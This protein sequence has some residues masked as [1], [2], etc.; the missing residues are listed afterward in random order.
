MWKV[1][2]LG[3]APWAAIGADL[4]SELIPGGQSL[5]HAP[6]HLAAGTG[7]VIIHTHFGSSFVGDGSRH[8]RIGRDW[9]AHRVA[10]AEYKVAQGTCIRRRPRPSPSYHWYAGFG[11]TY[12]WFSGHNGSVVRYDSLHQISDDWP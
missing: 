7:K 4:A 12:V 5:A 11:D 6:L 8:S 9:E 10:N 2:D 1:R 3:A